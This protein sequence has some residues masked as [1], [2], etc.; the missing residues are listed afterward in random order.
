MRSDEQHIYFFVRRRRERQIALR[1]YNTNLCVL[2]KSEEDTYALE[3][4]NSH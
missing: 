4:R 3:E 1:F 2:A